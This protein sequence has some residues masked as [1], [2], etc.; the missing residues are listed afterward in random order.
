MTKHLTS[1]IQLLTSSFGA[2]HL[3]RLLFAEM[4]NVSGVFTPGIDQQSAADASAALSSERCTPRDR[5]LPEFSDI[6]ITENMHKPQ[7]KM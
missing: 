6:G 5:H 2:D 4:S 3:S 7:Y 1:A